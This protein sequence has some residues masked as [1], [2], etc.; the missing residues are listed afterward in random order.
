M[1]T[2]FLESSEFYHR[3]YANFSTL[4]IVPLCMAMVIVVIISFIGER[5]MVIK[6]VGEI[7]PANTVSIVQSTSGSPI[8]IN[9][10]GEGREVHEGDVLI[11]Y[12]SEQ[13]GEQL[14]SLREQLRVEERKRNAVERL[15][16]GFTDNTIA[17][18]V[19]DEFGY[20]ATL[21]EYRAQIERLQQT[22]QMQ[23]QAKTQ[24][25]AAMQ[26]ARDA[27]G[28]QIAANDAQLAAYAEL[29]QA[30]DEGVDLPPHNMFASMFAVYKTQLKQSS[31]SENDEQ[32]KETMLANIDSAVRQLQESNNALTAQQAGVSDDNMGTENEETLIQSLRAQYEASA[33]KD[34]SQ[35]KADTLQIQTNIALAQADPQTKDVTALQDGILHVEDGV[36]G[37]KT[38]APG[39]VVAQIYPMLNERT[40]LDI[41]V[42]VPAN[43][44]DGVREGQVVRLTC[45]DSSPSALVLEGSIH[46]IAAAPTRTQQGN[47]YEVKATIA[48]THAQLNQIRYGLQGAV[49][50]ITG[51][52]TLFNYYR[53]ILFHR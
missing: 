12:D 45:P 19:D 50:I 6:S 13:S 11:S 52:K 5:E 9:N 34:L 53:D 23:Q 32:A 29:R 1:E 42:M 4:I 22:T 15:I 33:N 3:R 17:A 2:Q 51:R 48:P 30:V 21:A 38:I 28:A 20:G 7:I 27:I 46:F 8:A 37:V 39:T 35:I 36:T 14:K 16:Q 24:K 41:R 40:K 26:E 10:L 47:Y 25:N 44:I 43:K 49:V 18:D 31:T